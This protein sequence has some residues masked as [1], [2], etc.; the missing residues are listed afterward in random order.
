MNSLPPPPGPRPAP[1]S[2]PP[3]DPRVRDVAPDFAGM[4]ALVANLIPPAGAPMPVVSALATSRELLRHAYYR[5]EF[6]TVA[7]TH[8]LVALD[9][10]L[11]GCPAGRVGPG[12]VGPELAAELD[13]CRLLRERLGQGAVSSAALGPVRAA[14]MV[15]AVF[16]AVSLLLGPPTTAER[17]VA[18]AGAVAAAGD[19][20]A[21]LWEE[22][23]SAPFPPGFRGVDIEGVE[24]VLLDADVAALVRRELDGG[25]DD[26]GVAALWACVADLGKVVPLIDEEYCAAYCVRLQ[27]MARLAA[28]RSVP[29]AV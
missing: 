3:P 10:V 21:E 24:L 23:R 29:S 26:D 20:L 13:R 8:A 15:R 9:Q 11:A 27:A 17:P 28:A 18:G 7:V 14:A 25:L 1:P 4:H 5:Y 2:P 16:D 12:R 22:H 6:A 19:R